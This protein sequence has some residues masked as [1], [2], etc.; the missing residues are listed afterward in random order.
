[1]KT[2]GIKLADGSF[3]PVLQEGIASEKKLDLTTAHN[4]QTKV[5]VDLYSSASCSMDDADYVDSLQIENLVAH[6]NGD[7]DISF[8]VSLNEENELSAKIVDTETGNQSKTTITL[9]SR[10]QEERLITDE[11][12]ISD[13][14]NKIDDKADDKKAQKVA[15]GA[16]AGIGLLAAAS[17]LREKEE[18]KKE[19]KQENQEEFS[20]DDFTLGDP[21]ADSTTEVEFTPAADDEIADFESEADLDNEDSFATE[22]EPEVGTD[23]DLD[24]NVEASSEEALPD[25]EDFSF[26]EATEEKSETDDISSTNNETDDAPESDTTIVED[27]TPENDATIADENSSLDDNP[28][29][30]DLPTAESTPSLDDT[31]SPDDTIFSDD[32]ELFSEDPDLDDIDTSDLNFDF[33]GD[34]SDEV[35]KNSA[36]ESSSDNFDDDKFDDFDFDEDKADDFSDDTIQDD[37]QFPDDFFDIDDDLSINNSQTSDSPSGA[38]EN[39]NDNISTGGGISFTGLYDK[40]DLNQSQSIFED[41]DDKDVKKKTK[42]PVIICVVCA[43]ICIIATLLVLFIIP[44]KYNLISKKEAK[45]ETVVEKV[46]TEP[47]AEALPI[48]EEPAAP[49]EEPEPEPEPEPEVP[50]AKEDEIVIIEKAEDVVPEQ[51]PVSEEKPK[52]INYKIKWGDTLW[53]IADTY[54]KNPWRYKYI[55]RWNNIKDPDYIISGNSIII[56]SE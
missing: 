26:N 21:D 13:S 7:P 5:M 16:V 47:E 39:T 22:G 50:P 1:M 8:T 33:P 49:V 3:Y 23:T 41:D 38:S 2:I 19:E 29:T 9:V 15:A 11:Y 6:P 43:V 40:D 53:D 17:A 52:S 36:N 45:P 54:Y 35:L 25:F 32:D 31:P 4:N 55:A 20:D 34:D 56:P 24:T 37:N 14:E 28:T 51:P 10:T 12:N 42:V 46:E 30:N 48:E 18:Q 44:S 27:T